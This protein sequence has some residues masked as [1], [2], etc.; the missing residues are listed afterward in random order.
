[1]NP[2]SDDEIRERFSALRR[3]DEGLA[4][5]F[6][7]LAEEAARAVPP[8][9]HS[10]PRLNRVALLSFAAA[11]TL[12]LVVGTA[13]RRLREREAAQPPLALWTSPTAS[14]LRTPGSNLLTASTLTPSVF[15]GLTL[16]TH[17][18]T[19]R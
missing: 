3:A 4:P 7:R 14:L 5:S 17:T 19:G 16:M 1:M 18:K 15:D 6:A 10:R 2:L 8:S 9:A 13:R 12:L 11:A